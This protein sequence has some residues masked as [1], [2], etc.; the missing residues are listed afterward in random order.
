MTKWIMGIVLLAI[1]GGGLWWSGLLKQYLP[2][3]EPTAMMEHPATTTPV[4]QPVVTDLPTQGNDASEA[5]IVQDTAALDVQFSSLS[6]DQSG[7]DQ[8]LND[9]PVTQEF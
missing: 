2:M 6:S 5:A 8:S 3:S 4:Q 1:A 9:K 7:V